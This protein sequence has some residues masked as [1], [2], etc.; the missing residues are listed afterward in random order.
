VSDDRQRPHDAIRQDYDRKGFAEVLRAFR[1][2]SSPQ[3]RAAEHLLRLDLHET[4]EFAHYNPEA[5][6]QVAA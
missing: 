3:N 4:Y 5:L 2:Y 6:R 1:S